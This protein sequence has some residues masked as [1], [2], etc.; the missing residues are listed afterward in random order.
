MARKNDGASAKT[1]V[2][3]IR[4]QRKKL[5]VAC[6]NQLKV[7][8]RSRARSTRRSSNSF[9]FRAAEASPPVHVLSLS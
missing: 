5:E 4:Q 7:A 3:L 1:I 6:S 9:S 8:S 2:N